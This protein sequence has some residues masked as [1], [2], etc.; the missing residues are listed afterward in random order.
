MDSH[1]FDIAN[2]GPP[3]SVQHAVRRS[4]AEPRGKSPLSCNW[5]R[6]AGTIP[7]ALP[8]APA[9]NRRRMCPR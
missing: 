9:A 3:P 2:T 1:N 8:D 4:A 6:R 5:M 7:L